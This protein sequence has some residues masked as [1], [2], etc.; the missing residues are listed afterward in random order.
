M[1]KIKFYITAILSSLLLSCGGSDDEVD[2]NV[3]EQ[4]KFVH[5]LLLDRY[6]WYTEVVPEINYSDFDSPEQ[7]LDFLKFH[8]LD[9]FSYITDA[10]TFDSLFEDG[11]YLGYGFSYFK[12]NDGTVPIK[13]VYD[14][15]PAG[16]AG[17]QRGDLIISINRQLVEDISTTEWDDIFGPAEEG[18]PV[19]LVVQKK[20]GDMENLPMEKAIVNINT[21]LSHSV[22]NDGAD[23]VGYMAFN[24]FLATSN[25]EI[26]QVFSNFN[27]AAVNKMILDLRYN[28][29]GRVSVAQNL[30]SFM[31]PSTITNEVFVLL[32]Q[33]DKHQDLN[34][35][36]YFKSRVNELDLD[37]VVVITSGST[38]SASEIM[39]NGLK[40]F[41]DVKTV[42][43]KTYGKPVGMNPVEFDDKV[44]LP[45]TFSNYNANG[46][47]DYFDGIDYDCF[48]KDDLSFDFGD[49]DEPM[50]AEAL[51]VSQNGSC[52]ATKSA[53]KLINH[54]Q[55]ET[56]YS[57]Q[58]IIGAQ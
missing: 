1:L 48:V 42:G 34:H 51:V 7:T 47:G 44:I 30:A 41:V 27:A 54:R 31:V 55:D 46:Q 9:R 17:L 37:R 20:N 24:S 29:G 14:D 40:P 15:S 21:V 38:A 22:I 43:N 56:P 23:T 49:T 12:E 19:L 52:S 45:I 33:N 36:Y 35:S 11:Q 3:Y 8:E 58:A 39:I 13:F 16:R 53:A 4:N 2:D 10:S 32:K 6:L 18:H 25:Q 50:L 57:L 26:E 28:G 5:E